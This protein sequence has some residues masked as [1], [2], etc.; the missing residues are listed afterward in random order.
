MLQHLRKQNKMTIAQQCSVVL[1]DGSK[2]KVSEANTLAVPLKITVKI[3]MGLKVRYLRPIS[4]LL[5]P[6]NKIR[7]TYYYKYDDVMDLLER[8]KVEVPH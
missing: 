7:G 4:L 1:Q 3:A 5:L 8:N 6:C 2:G